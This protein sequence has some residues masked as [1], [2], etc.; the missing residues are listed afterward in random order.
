MFRHSQSRSLAAITLAF[1]TAV[2]CAQEVATPAATAAV[3]QTTPETKAPVSERLARQADDAYLAGAHQLSSNDPVAAEKNFARAF[4]LNPARSEYQLALALAREQHVTALVQKAARERTLGHTEASTKLLAEARAVDPDN[5]I[6]DQH[7]GPGSQPEDTAPG[8]TTAHDAIA[9]LGGPIHLMPKGDKKSFHVRGDTQQVLREV[10]EAFGIK[11][12][13]DPS[14]A[15]Q[16]MRFDLEDVDFATAQRILGKMTDSFAVPLTGSS[17][18]LAK[19]T[20]DNRDHLIPLVEETL[21]IPGFLPD[22]LTELQNIAKNVFDIK[23]TYLGKDPG[24]LILR[25]NEDALKLVNATFA[26]MI[27][28]GGEVMLQ[29][30]VFEY[31]RTKG[32]NIGASIPGQLGVFSVAGEAQQI[33]S[34]NQSLINQAIANGLLVLGDNPVQNLVKEALFLIASGTVTSTQLTNF[35]GYF[36]GGLTLGGVYLGSNTTVNLLL[37]SSE[38]RLLD[39]VQLRVQDNQ[40]GKV[41][42]GSR[43]PVTTSTYSSGISSSLSS[44]LAGV[45]VNGTSAASLLSQYLGGNNTATI[46][47]V[48][49]EDLGLT[50]TATPQIL[51]A[52]N[53]HI[54]VELKIEALGGSSL[55]NIPILNQRN[56]TSDVTVPVGQTA[57]IASEVSRSEVRSMTGIP[58][59][60]EIPGFQG[61]DT[62]TET[63]TGELLITITPTIVRHRSA[64]IATRRLLANVSPAEQ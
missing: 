18:L 49:Y 20:Q 9:R 12:T 44:A 10:Y 24:R 21:D 25:G 61:T 58:G 14:M 34:Q 7:F 38:A 39:E 48:Q 40:Q 5:P 4:A 41:R 29:V 28:G 59:L 42:S 8:L 32:H 55:N 22:Q 50:L 33:V 3:A 31:D 62:S 16:Q 60:N 15:H 43:Y 63:D 27:D 46:P 26:D 45:K 13:F 37:N 54:K 53:V 1:A 57:M 23:Q 19:D 30:H 35:L 64:I 56:L 2:V 17:A 36:G 52:G 11:V 51:K 47:Q 6:V